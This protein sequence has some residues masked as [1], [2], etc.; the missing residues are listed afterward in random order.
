MHSRS[1]LTPVVQGNQTPEPG[2]LDLC[3]FRRLV[4]RKPGRCKDR[5]STPFARLQN[6]GCIANQES[7]LKTATQ[8]PTQ[9]S[10]KEA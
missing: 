4:L 8:Q 5:R 9:S 7:W 3:K 2:R 10:G 6:Q 1:R